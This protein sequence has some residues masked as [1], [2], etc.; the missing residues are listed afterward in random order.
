[1]EATLI[2]VDRI[3]LLGL[4]TNYRYLISQAGPHMSFEK[5]RSLPE[6][7]IEDT[8]RL[9][10]RS[11]VLFRILTRSRIINSRN[12]RYGIDH[13]DVFRTITTSTGIK[14]II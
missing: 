4:I 7:I 11:P 12:T 10:V 3:L 1:M 2:K 9:C 14:E 5:N 6:T 8:R 13:F